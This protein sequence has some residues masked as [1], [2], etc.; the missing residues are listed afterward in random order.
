[1]VSGL[2]A[3]TLSPVMSSRFVHPSGQ[4]GRLTA[5]VNR[6]FEAV[7]RV[8]ARVLDGAFGM[9]W[10]IVRGRV[11]VTLAVPGRCTSISRQELA[12]VEDQSHISLFFEASPDSTLAQTN[13]DHLQ[14]VGRAA[15]SSRRRISPGR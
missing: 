9:R 7:R 12:P 11:L 14:V 13:R 15:R 8:Y 6:G 1:M 2:V 10:A 5:I 4:E 3:L